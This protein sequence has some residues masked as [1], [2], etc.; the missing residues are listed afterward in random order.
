M[1]LYKLIFIAL[2]SSTLNINANPES[3]SWQ[4]WVINLNTDKQIKAAYNRISNQFY[5][6][7]NAA[8]VTVASTVAQSTDI[9]TPA[10]IG[11]DALRTQLSTFNAAGAKIQ[12]CE[13][14]RT[15]LPDFN[16]A[17]HKFKPTKFTTRFLNTLNDPWVRIAVVAGIIV[18]ARYKYK[19]E[20]K[21][22][23]NLTVEE[24]TP[25]T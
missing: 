6:K 9:A 2:L 4:S 24:E 21:K 11:C 5:Q 1:K 19:Q 7:K 16:K 8:M 15:Q 3:E 10:K 18:Y 12:K 13:A 14:L 17:F 20:Q 22:P 25:A 23:K